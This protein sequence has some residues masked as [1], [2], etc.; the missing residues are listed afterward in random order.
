MRNFRDWVQQSERTHTRHCAGTLK[1]S[2]RLIAPFLAIIVLVWLSSFL[3][4][5]PRMIY[6]SSITQPS[7]G[8]T[9]N[10]AGVGSELQARLNG[11]TFQAVTASSTSGGN[12]TI[13]GNGIFGA[14]G[15]ASI[16]EGGAGGGQVGWTDSAG[17]GL[18]SEAIS[19][20][21]DAT[22]L[23]LGSPN[24]NGVVIWPRWGIQKIPANTGYTPYTCNGTTP[25]PVGTRGLF[26]VVY[27][28][29]G[30]GDVLQDCMQLADGTFSWTEV[31]NA[32]G[33]SRV[34]TQFDKTADTTL[35]NV[36][37]LSVSLPVNARTYSFRAVL[38]VTGDVVG[39]Q[40]YAI[41]GTAGAANI[42]Y[43]I[44]TVSNTANTI[45]ISSRQ[46]ALGGSAGQAGATSDYTTIDGTITLN[47]AG[48]LTVQFA[49]NA[50]NGTSSVLVGS[51]L[52]A[53]QLSP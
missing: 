6:A 38:H 20:G 5:A 48:T 28:A 34:S 10:P 1:K 39:G 32:G 17:N 13:V 19:N 8:G 14:H 24:V 16:G 46:T 42:I 51:T 44:V 52:V 4:F 7:G 47:V 12:I 49:Q 26:G 37:G 29:A 22:S 11:T 18:V 25:S 15:R 9:G 2:L 23:W 45:V 3:G 41:S 53:Q 50:A 27:G 21:I 43:N 33:T 31:K 30:F 35:A 36:P 40:K